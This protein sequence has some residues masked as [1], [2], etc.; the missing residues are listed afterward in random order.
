MQNLIEPYYAT[1]DRAQN[2]W[3]FLYDNTDKKENYEQITHP[4][5]NSDFPKHETSVRHV[6]P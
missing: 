5:E 4:G 1:S 6:Y 2:T 3:D